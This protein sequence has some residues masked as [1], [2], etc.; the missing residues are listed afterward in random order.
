M[1]TAW[2]GVDQDGNL[3]LFDTGEAGAIPVDLPGFGESSQPLGGHPD[4]FGAICKAIGLD[5]EDE[6]QDFFD[7]DVPIPVYRYVHA[8]PTNLAGRYELQ[9][10]PKRPGRIAEVPVE[11]RAG[12]LRLPVRFADGPPV[13]PAEH[14][15]CSAW[16]SVWV[17]A[18]GTIARALPGRER[19]AEK[20]WREVGDPSVRFE[21]ASGEILTL[22]AAAPP[23]S[24]PLPNALPPR[25]PAS[26]TPDEMRAALGLPPRPAAPPERTAP[27]GDTPATPGK[28]WWKFW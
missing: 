5:S 1:D 25:S 22:D 7:P 16:A 15:P 18:D 12:I 17:S 6:E 26:S 3:A 9:H 11:L 27:A 13:Q 28:P 19:D 4:G 8:E 21:R 14:V 10:T 20:E 24:E 2:F 23:P